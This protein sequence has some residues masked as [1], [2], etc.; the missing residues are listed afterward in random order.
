MFVL[1]TICDLDK[2]M[3]TQIETKAV[4]LVYLEGLY[5]FCFRLL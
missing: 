1:H 2:V 3:G 4:N 5:L